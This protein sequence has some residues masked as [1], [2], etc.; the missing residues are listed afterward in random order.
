MAKSRNRK[1]KEMDKIPMIARGSCEEQQVM[2]VN[3]YACHAMRLG[4]YA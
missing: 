1:G 4:S 3:T 2:V